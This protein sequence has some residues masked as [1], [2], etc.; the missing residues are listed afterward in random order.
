VANN[1]ILRDSVF[2]LDDRNSGWAA[3]QGGG[4]E[5]N[6]FVSQGTMSVE[7][8]IT[9]SIL[10]FGLMLVTAAVSWRIVDPAPNGAT[11]SLTMPLILGGS[12]IG[13]GAAL[14]ASFRPA[15]APVVAPIYAIAQGFLVGAVSALY[16]FSYDGIV[17]QATLATAA[18]F[19]T[20]LGLYRFRIIRVT[21][22]MRSVV[23]GLTMG[24]AVFYM[25]SFVLSFFT[26]NVPLIG[27]AGIFGLV[28]SVFVIGVA[29]FN[30]LTDFDFIERGSEAQLDK[31]Y[32]WVA[33]IG[34]LATV[35]WL[36]LEML[37]LISK[38]QQR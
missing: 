30:L 24:I 6:P 10:L 8:T 1:P 21:E 12:L 15:T 22:R 5:A 33:A 25:F 36:Y 13:L 14:L 7:S 34:I 38:L 32:E 11:S 9:K 31:K 4:S 28:F 3:P 20:M 18:V 23:F 35:V 19:F 26:D 27:D 2:G 16:A 17:V 37:R 29:A